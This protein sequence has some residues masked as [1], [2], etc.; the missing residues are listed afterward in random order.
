MFLVNGQLFLPT[1]GSAREFFSLHTMAKSVL[2]GTSL[3]N[4][5]EIY[6]KSVTSLADVIVY[7]FN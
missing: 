4:T 6:L 2:K 5:A 1:S 7:T 3:Y